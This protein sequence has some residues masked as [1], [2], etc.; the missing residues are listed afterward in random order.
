MRLCLGKVFA[1]HAIGHQ[2]V[3]CRGVPLI[4]YGG[5]Q[6]ARY[7]YGAANVFLLPTHGDWYQFTLLDS[8]GNAYKRGL[9][10]EM[11][12]ERALKLDSEV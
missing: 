5:L 3:V 11:W 10:R 4:L 9:V 8:E 2:R 12:Q 7:I 6:S 1:I